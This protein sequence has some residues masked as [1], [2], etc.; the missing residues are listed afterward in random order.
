VAHCVW[1]SQYS[2][3][4]DHP[5]SFDEVQ[6]PSGASPLPAAAPHHSTHEAISLSGET[7][8]P[9]SSS[10]QQ[11]DSSKL[12]SRREWS[13]DELRSFSS[14]G[15]AGM[16]DPQRANGRQESALL[17]VIFVL[18]LAQQALSD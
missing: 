17:Q 5:Y 9:A 7:Q 13:F 14:L 12:A 6:E 10:F 11:S 1:F 15:R 16:A 2:F 18:R 8:G 4:G 3:D